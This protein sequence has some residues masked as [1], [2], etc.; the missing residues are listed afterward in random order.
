MSASG[1]TEHI[2]ERSGKDGI[3][4]IDQFEQ[5]YAE[6]FGG[7]DLSRLLPPRMVLVGI[8]VDPAAER[9]ARFISGGPVDLSMV[10]F[11]GFMRGE[12]RLLGTATGG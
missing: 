3:E 10:T 2:A 4:K 12:E 11:H 7:D 6:N 1:L 5:W 8:G 9:M